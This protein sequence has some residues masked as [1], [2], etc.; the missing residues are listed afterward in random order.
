MSLLELKHEVTRLKKHER[1]DLHAYLIRL[2]HETPEWKKATAARLRAI[3][4]GK[5][6]PAES[7]ARQIGHG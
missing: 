7:L 3:K 5:G 1:E 6:V 2:R 4:R